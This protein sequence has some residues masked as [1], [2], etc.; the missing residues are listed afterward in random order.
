MDNLSLEQEI[1]VQGEYLRSVINNVIE[2]IITISPDRIVEM[3]NP[4][5]ERIFGYEAS[6]VIGNNISMLMPEPYRS[7]HDSYV[8]NYLN[9]GIKKIIGIG[10][11]VSGRRKDG[12]IFPLYLAVSEMNHGDK[13]RFIGIIRDITDVKKAEASL[14]ESEKRFRHMAD[15]APVLIRMSG[16]DAA[17]EYLNK[18]WLDY[19]GRPPEQEL[20]NGWLEGVHPD[21]LHGCLEALGV[22]FI[23]RRPFEVEYRL[24]RF[25]G[26]YRWILDKGVPRLDERG[27]FAGYI[28][29]CNDIDDRRAAESALREMTILQ[30]AI[31]DS[32]NYSIISTD[33]DG[34]ITTFNTAAQRWL[35]YSAEEV[36]GKATP[37]ILHDPE[38]VV[39]HARELS[40]LLG[41]TVEPGFDAFVARARLGVPD[42]TEWTYVRKDGSRFTV[43]LSVTAL[44]DEE[45]RIKGFLGVGSDIAARKSAEDAVA[46]LGAIIE[47]SD[48][49]IIGKTLDGTIVSWNE[50]AERIYGYSAKEILGK[51]Y[52]LLAPP[53]RQDEVREILDRLNRGE[54]VEHFETV[55]RRKDGNLIDVSLSKSPIRNAEGRITGISTIAR[56]ITGRKLAEE[57]L[58]KLSRAVEQS[59]VTVV[60][61]DTKGTIEYVNPKFSRVTGYLPEEVLGRNPRILKSGDKSPEEYKELWGTITSGEEWRGVFHNKK[62]D[63]ELYWE[64]ASIS[65]IKD[66]NG[67][68]THFVAVKEDITALKKA[69]EELEKL[70][71]VASKTDNAVIITDSYGCIEWVNEGFVRLTGYSLEEAVGKKPGHIL[72][73]PLSDSVTVRR[74]GM[75]IRAAKPFTEEILNYHKNGHTYWVSM[76]VTPIFDGKGEVIRFISIESDITLR[77]EAEEALQQAKDA[78]DRANQAKSEFLAG[79]SHE[80]RTPMNAIIGMAELLSETP[81]SSEQEKYVEVFRSAGETLL[82]IINDILDI[83]KVEAG[84]IH[85]ENVGFDLEDLVERLCEVMAVRAHQKGIELACRIMPEVPTGLMGDPGRLRQVL[86]NL[87][88]NAIKFTEE[89]QVI[90]EIKLLKA[91]QEPLPGGGHG[92]CCS[93]D[94]SVSDTGIGIAPEKVDLIFEKFSQADTSITR[95]YGGTG[96]GLAISRQLVELMGGQIRVES[97]VGEGSVF[98]FSVRLEIQAEPVEDVQ[99]ATGDL[100]G[101]R[102]LIVD[103]NSTNRMILK[104]MITRWGASAIEAQDGE[105]GVAELKRARDAGEP[106]RVVLLDRRMPGMNGFDVAECIKSDPSLAHMAV[107]MLTSDDRSGDIGRSRELGMQSYLVKPIKRAELQNALMIAM[108]RSE[109]SYR[110]KSEVAPSVVQDL[111]PLRILLVEDSPDNRLLVEAYLKHTPYRIDTAE[112][113]QIGVDKFISQ[114]Y[115]LVLMDM[116][117]PVMDGYTATRE[118]RKW[119]SRERS[120]PVPILALTAYALKEEARKTLEAGCTVHLTKPIKKAGLLEAIATHAPS[121][122]EEEAAEPSEKITVHV[123]ADLEDLIPEFMKNR[124]KDI[125]ALSEAIEAKDF[126]AIRVIGHTLKGVGGGYGF[127]FLTDMGLSLETAA[128]EENGAGIERLIEELSNVIQSVEVVYE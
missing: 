95:K 2:G 54:R 52:S 6:E 59:P 104:E 74:I 34:T 19:T 42:E 79:M 46:Q 44:R 29:S 121:P 107:M 26:E 24:K 106:Y 102:I 70:S 112:N 56:D 51:P 40:K 4:A 71:L 55:R 39:R 37:A 76:N 58:R 128:R 31:L 69:E 49:A 100:T 32:A 67:A 7:E 28:S 114:K 60:I 3:F 30:R 18:V 116:E 9:T 65:P 1:Q 96:L 108:G 11:E 64:S 91:E 41:I 33:P 48:D 83:S 110:L 66:S 82:T 124:R 101:V 122:K 36:V 84:Q 87:I 25:D 27:S 127:H 88:G 109:A 12:V 94:F 85:L 99:P 21:D 115:D 15:S 38:E 45:N 113:G 105:H 13:R 111:S 20:G 61:T 47:S 14:R 53:D 16:P 90:L 17:C 23:Q 8:L 92:K 86:M 81:L 97:K 89:G 73:G 75:L 120:G 72:Q 119:E 63:G 5:A 117:M 98:S 57:Q 78:A 43:L 103:D 77:K 10:R 68:I 35:G 125:L 123:D 62:K 118:I 22:S 93:L 80:I 50:S 126:E